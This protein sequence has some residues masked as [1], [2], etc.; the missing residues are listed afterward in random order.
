MA[1][2]SVQGR[3][4]T[5]EQQTRVKP[6]IV[7]VQEPSVWLTELVDQE[8]EEAGTRQ[9]VARQLEFVINM[10]AQEIERLEEKKAEIETTLNELRVIHEGS[11]ARLAK[12]RGGEA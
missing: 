5:C 10:T 7:R 1:V 11:K 8:D 6:A 3:A 2:P 4:Q 9:V 12:R